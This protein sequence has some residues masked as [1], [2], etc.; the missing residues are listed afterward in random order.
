MLAFAVT[1][2]QNGDRLDKT[3]A[4]ASNDLSRA[5]LQELIEGAH[6]A[7]AGEQADLTSRPHSWPDHTSAGRHKQ[8]GVH[9][10]WSP[11][12]VVT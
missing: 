3:L 9:V 7:Y 6:E 1:Y 8:S 12:P 11:P 2:A 10:A 4:A 5:R